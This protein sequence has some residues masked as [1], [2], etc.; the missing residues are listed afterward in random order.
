MRH[1]GKKFEQVL[2]EKLLVDL[3][4]QRNLNYGRAKKIAKE[5]NPVGVGAILVH[6]RSDG[7][8]V[9]LDGQHRTAAMKILG[10]TKIDC[11][12]YEGMTP[13][14]EALA[15]EY[16]QLG[17]PQNRLQRFKSSV[18]GGNE[19][20][21][22]IKNIVERLGH[23]IHSEITGDGIKSYAT[24]EM[25]YKNSGEN[26]LIMVLSLINKIFPGEKN[27]V[28]KNMMHGM[29]LFLSAYLGKFDEKTLVRKLKLATANGVLSQARILASANRCPEYKG[30]KMAITNIYNHGRQD[31]IGEI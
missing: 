26:G 7:S 22:K 17:K 30:V 10:F 13:Q 15:F 1:F 14:E 16:Y 2:I 11:D 23:Q 12:V 21:I 27:V 9:I 29:Y 3:E 25:I 5:F 31:K 18:A 8:Y 24:I 20:S 4:Y 6:K 19:T 28:S